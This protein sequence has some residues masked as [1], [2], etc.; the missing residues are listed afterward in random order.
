MILNKG[1][2]R[3]DYDSGRFERD[4]RHINDYLKAKKD[5][6]AKIMSDREKTEAEYQ[7]MTEL[8]TKIKEAQFYLDDIEKCHVE[9]QHKS[10]LI[11]EL[12]QATEFLQ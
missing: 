11:Q 4:W 6:L 5:E 9:L 2:E 3:G 7:G 1:K 8:Q 12:E 10:I